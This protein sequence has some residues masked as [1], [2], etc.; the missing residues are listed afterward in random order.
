MTRKNFLHIYDLSKGGKIVQKDA[1][2]YYRSNGIWKYL[3]TIRGYR[4]IL[5]AILQCFRVCPHPPVC[6]RYDH[7]QGSY[8]CG[9]MSRYTSFSENF[10]VRGIAVENIIFKYNYATICFW[11]Q[12]QMFVNDNSFLRLF[13]LFL[14]PQSRLSHQIKNNGMS[15]GRLRQKK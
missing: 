15:F 9:A 6:R 13:V 12:E 5:R 10:P 8:V 1:C 2:M 11:N 4:Q 7:I 14:Q 3:Y